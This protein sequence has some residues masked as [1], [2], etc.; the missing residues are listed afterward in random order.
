MIQHKLNELV[1]QSCHPEIDQGNR[2]A[3]KYERIGRRLEMTG[4]TIEAVSA[5]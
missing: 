5:Q 3:V 1:I 2:L 4:Q